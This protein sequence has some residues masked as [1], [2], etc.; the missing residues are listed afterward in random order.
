MFRHEGGSGK[1]WRVMM[2]GSTYK[3]QMTL[4]C[5]MMVPQPKGYPDKSIT[6]KNNALQKI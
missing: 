3:G 6:P 2:G 5:K 1:E 4:Y